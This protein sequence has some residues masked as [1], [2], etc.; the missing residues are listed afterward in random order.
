[1]H[2]LV[3]NENLNIENMEI[4]DRANSGV[5]EFIRV[6]F[7]FLYSLSFFFLVSFLEFN[8]LKI[9]CTKSVIAS[10]GINLRI[11]TKIAII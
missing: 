3:A 10:L 11:T 5:I 8:V 6:V 2:Y 4:V 7:N 1:M 9:I